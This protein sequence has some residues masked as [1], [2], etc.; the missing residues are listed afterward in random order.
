V[1]I[2][3]TEAQVIDAIELNFHNIFLNYDNKSYDFLF[4]ISKDFKRKE[5]PENSSEN[6]S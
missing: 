3:N 1:N 6:R 4:K 5:K 2:V